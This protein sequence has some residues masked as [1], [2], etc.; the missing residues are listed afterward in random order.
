MEEVFKLGKMAENMT[1]NKNSTKK[2]DMVHICGQMVGNKKVN[3]KMANNT[4]LV[5]KLCQTIVEKL[6]SG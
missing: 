3:G 1:V 2:M 4:E 5:I 6:E